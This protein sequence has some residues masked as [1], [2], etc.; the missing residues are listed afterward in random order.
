MWPAGRQLAHAVAYS[1]FKP[2][3]FYVLFSFALRNA[4]Y[5]GQKQLSYNKNREEYISGG[6]DLKKIC[7]IHRL[8]SFVSANVVRNL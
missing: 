7:V 2:I 4:R 8:V 1:N 6:A 3:I 5:C